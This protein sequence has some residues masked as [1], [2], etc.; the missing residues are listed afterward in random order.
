MMH[1]N[2]PDALIAT[3]RRLAKKNKRDYYV[4]FEPDHLGRYH[5]CDDYDLDGFYMGISDHNILYSTWNN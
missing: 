4:I 3:A 5:V 1:A 2:N